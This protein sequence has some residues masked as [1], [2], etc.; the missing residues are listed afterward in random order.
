MA[1]ADLREELN[2]SICLSIYTDPVMLSCGHNFCQGCIGSVLDTQEGS[3]V[4][5]CPECRA[6]YQERPA[7]QRNMKLC[8]IAERFLTNHPEQEETEIFCT[9]CDSPVPAAKTCLH[10]DASLCDKHLKKHSK[11]PE[12]VLMEPTISLEKRKCSI[13]KE[14]LKYY[15]TKDAVCVCLVCCAFGDH[16]GHQVELINEASEKK[17]VKLRNVLEKLTSKRKNT[18]KRVQS[19]EEHRREVQGKAAGVTERVTALIMDT[20]KQL[21]ALEK[22]VLEEI[23][24]QKE[25]VLLQVSDLIQQL[26]REKDELSIQMSHIEE[27][28]N[29]TD[30]ITVLQREE[31]EKGRNTECGD[32]DL[33]ASEELDEVLIS[34]RLH[35]ALSDIVTDVKAKRGLCEQEAPDI[36]L[37]VN[38]ACCYMSVSG[39]F[40]TATYTNIIQ[41]RPYSPESFVTYCQVL[42]INS[43]TSGRHYWEVETSESGDCCVGLAYPSIKREGK[44]SLIGNNNRSWCLCYLKKK[45][46]VWHNSK[47]TTVTPESSCTRLGVFLDYEAGRLSFYQLCDPVRLLHTFTATFTEPLHAA[48]YV[49]RAWVRIKRG[50]VPG[51]SL[52]VCQRHIYLY[53]LYGNIRIRTDFQFLFLVLLPSM[54][55]ADLREE[56][57]CSICLSIYTD[58]VMLSCGHNFCQGCIGDVLDT[59]EGSGVYTCPECRAEYQERPAPQ[60]NLKLCNIAKRFLSNHPEQEETEIFCTYCDSPVPAAKTCLHCE[61]S[62]CDKHL[63]KHSKSPEHVLMEPTIS[64]ENRKCSIHQKLLEYY[65][66]EDAVCVCVSCFA[67]GDHKGHRVEL[68]NEASEKK[69]MK[70]RN[71]LEK[72]TSK[73]RNTEKK[74]QS[75]EEHRREVQGKAAGVRERVTAL[76]MD[77]RKQLE[78]LEKSVLEEITRQKEEVLLQVSDLIQQLER[79]KD[80]LSIEMSHIEELCNM[81]DPITVIQREEAEKGRNT[82]C[83]DKDLPALE[84]LDEVLISVRL[85]RGLSDIVTD[86]KAKRGLCEQDAP[87]ILLDVNTACCYMSVSGDLKTATYTNI[88]QERP[89]RPERFVHLCQVL[90]INSFTSG[91]HYWEVETSE[92]GDC[93]VGLAYPSIEREGK[94]SL[95]GNN[96]RSWCLCYLKKKKHSVQHNSILTPLTPESSCTRLGIFLDYEAG[97]LYFYQLCDP[98]RH[99]HTFTATFTEPLHAPFYVHRAWVRIKRGVP[100]MRGATG[101]RIQEYA[102][103]TSTSDDVIRMHP[104]V[105]I[106][107][108]LGKRLDLGNK[109]KCV[110]GLSLGV[111]QRHIYLYTLYGNIR[112]RTDFQF[113][114][115]VLLPS[116]ASADLRE[117]L[118]CSIC[119]SI[120]TDP[121]MLS[122]GHN[123]CQGC[124][125]D[126]LDTQEGSGVYTC[127]ECRAEYQERPAPQ[128]NLKLCNIAKRFLSNHPEQEETEIFCTYCDSPVPA[129][130]TCLHCEASL[131]DKHLKKHSKSPEHVLMEPTISLENRKCSIH[132]KLLEYYC[133]EDAVCVCVSCFAFGDHKGHRVELLNE[134]SEKKKMKLRNVLEKLTSKRRNTEKKVQ[135]L[136]E[137]R[138]EVQGKAA[139]VRER[140]TALIMDTRKQLEALEKSVLEEITRQQEEVLL[141]VSD[142]IQQLEREKDELSIEMSHIEELCNMTDPITVIQR[143][144]AEK[145]R[146]TECGDKDLPA[147]EELD[148]VLISVRLHRGLSDIVTD[149]KAK[150]GLCEQ[151]APDILLDVNT[152]CC[153]MSVSGDLKTATYT[154]ITQERPD[155]PERFVHLC[156]VLSIN[157]FTSGRH[158]WEVETS[159]SGD[160][161]VGLAY[162]SIEREGKPSLIGNNNRSWCLCYLKKKKHSV[163]HNSILT[164]LTPE[165]SCTRLGIFLDYEAGRLY[166][167]QL[168]DPIRHLHTFTATFT[169][170]LHAAFYVH[171]AWVRIKRGVP[172]MRGATGIRIQEY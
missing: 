4:Y 53:T 128:R 87:D 155:R 78:A 70:L 11:S 144:E 44:P 162:P 57:N 143:E 150:R 110:P 33:P 59:Q 124:I 147:L 138:R 16:K 96:N 3:G 14:I 1:S 90:S 9:Y 10:C 43:F 170:P 114:F 37:D 111:C 72:L 115:L 154:N 61:A 51:L 32:K 153:Y 140:V 166:F 125:G 116:M 160:C 121:V 86:V 168:C 55:S 38:T 17:K 21:E 27:L 49:Y 12:H 129:A 105:L 163:Q 165:S 141:Q 54:A 101:I 127:P 99:L 149:V 19:L 164:P 40:K 137:H 159:E 98:I 20:R 35:R 84:E 80:E 113:L 45:H 92:S 109:H 7:P 169:E 123:F 93:C 71:V 46:S 97:R 42:S 41:E 36:L 30:P 158:Y 85:H 22:S 65:C 31:A 47:L 88:T 69:K 103:V 26:E 142:L 8:N 161:C 108:H 5:T 89:D 23:T 94:P 68:L 56:L 39:D 145:G 122:C 134:A 130:K 112:I 24:R 76:I 100:D 81:T 29:M 151:D 102:I 148:E 52:G 50:C 67:F 139:G 136:E 48:F 63:K 104:E 77:T 152:A 107:R 132:Q 13:H 28:C 172:D 133:T 75:L 106:D 118:N 91:R 6:E 25:E 167:Y 156:Q 79:E 131:C 119:L 34:V 157:S 15:C 62:L 126:V 2:C 18:E 64:L 73:R 83:G 120:Y 66:T 95:I 171:R 82:E 60:R 135:S 74:V 58:P 117:E 146:N